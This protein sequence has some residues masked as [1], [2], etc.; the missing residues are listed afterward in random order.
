MKTRLT[1]R[2]LCLVDRSANIGV[3]EWIGLLVLINHISKK[4]LCL[5][6]SIAESIISTIT[7]TVKS[8]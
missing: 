6:D 7:L 1:S 2:W 4:V 8:N 5:D 3:F